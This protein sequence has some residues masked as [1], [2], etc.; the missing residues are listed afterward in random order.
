MIKVNA[1]SK[2]EFT[3]SKYSKYLK[4]SDGTVYAD[5][6]KSANN[7]DDIVLA[8]T[9]YVNEDLKHQRKDKFKEFARGDVLIRVGGNDY[10][11]NV[12]VGFTSGKQMVLYG[13]I[14]FKIADFKIKKRTTR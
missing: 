1:I 6:F 5:K 11:A 3:N 7:L 2:S 4:S 9:N 8:S 10:S 14:N 12:I 13:I